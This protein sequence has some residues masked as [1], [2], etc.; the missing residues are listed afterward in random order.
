LHWGA[1]KNIYS[2]ISQLQIQ[3]TEAS[4]V[5]Q[6]RDRCRPTNGSALKKRTDGSLSEL[7]SPF[8]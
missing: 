2:S 6:G 4:S 3:K 8:P 7:L 1:I 5:A